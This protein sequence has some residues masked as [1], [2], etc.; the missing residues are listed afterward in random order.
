M[1][2]LMDQFLAKHKQKFRLLISTVS[3][4]LLKL[5]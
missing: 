3:G 1:W 2:Q 5:P 4:M